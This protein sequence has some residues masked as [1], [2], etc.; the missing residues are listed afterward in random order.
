MHR[1]LA[2]FILLMV[3]PGFGQTIPQPAPAPAG[4]RPR[5]G[6]SAAA[7]IHLT[8]QEAVTLA[9]ENNR[10][11]E[12]ER[13][14]IQRRQFD[15]AAAKGAYDPTLDMSF[16]YQRRTTPVSSFL[17][18]GENGKLE[19]SSL[20]SNTTITQRLPWQGGTVAFNFENNRQ[21]SQ[22]LFTTLNPEY[23]T[24]LNLTFTQPLF[25]N[26]ST[27][28]VRR[29]IRINSKRLDLSDIQFRQRVIDI[30]SQV[31]RSYWDLAYAYRNE[32]IRREAVQLAE[33]QLEQIQRMADKGT[34]APSEMISAR[35]EIERRTDEA[36]AALEDVQRA[37]NNLKSLMLQPTQTD[38]WNAMLLPVDQPHLSAP[39]TMSM[40][41]AL[42]TAFQN[43]P[44]MEQYRVKSE[45]N[46][47]DVAYYRNQ[48]KPQ[49]D[50]IA[51]Y[52]TTGLAGDPRTTDN[53]L[54]ST[55]QP[56][57]NRINQLSQLAGLPPLQ[58]VANNVP[59]Q[60]VGGYGTSLKNL[61]QNDFR[62]WQV[63]FN[64]NFSFGN[65][66]AKAQLGQALATE[67]QLDVERQRTQQGI[68]IEVRNALQ[69][70]E[71][72]YRR[73]EAASRSH[74]DA[75]LQYEAEQR[76][77]AAGLST[78]YL[79]LD[80]QNALSSAQGRKLK[81]LTDYN[82]AVT[83]LQRALATTLSSRNIVV[84]SKPQQD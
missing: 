22:N 23:R 36:E 15:L 21:T 13:I 20:A 47:A 31:N 11:I 52:G 17:A 43:R 53:P 46:Q 19:S 28:A 72:A 48:T 9:L 7:P 57:F 3:Q 63:G 33:T 27:D 70:V 68:E 55:T 67:R 79:I 42:K 41:E 61:F 74:T 38:K 51:G 2:L 77:F 24:G 6:V 44:E 80:R 78:N 45:L 10:D 83:D 59:S 14:E 34:V 56:L 16:S 75:G 64:V 60:F 12:V 8:L 39:E 66:T 50:F 1:T 32:A 65:H 18:G 62:S 84:N 26:R 49:V 81:A 30:I 58:P 35:V 69:S 5:V 4:P 82:K 37:E 54:T 76:K 40:D 73:V 29:Q 71:T 25:R